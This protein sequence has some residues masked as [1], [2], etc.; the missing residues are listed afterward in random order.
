MAGGE[1]ASQ[2]PLTSG[3]RSTLQ[4]LT[5]LRS[6]GREQATGGDGPEGR[7]RARTSTPPP[8]PLP[9]PSPLRGQDGTA[10]GARGLRVERVPT[11]EGG[12]GS[13]R[14]P[15]PHTHFLHRSQLYMLSPRAGEG[16]HGRRG[17]RG[18]MHQAMPSLHRTEGKTTGPQGHRTPPDRGQC[19]S[20]HVTDS[21]QLGAEGTQPQR[22]K[23]AYAQPT[24]NTRLHRKAESFLHGQG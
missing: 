5:P 7:L 21:S 3:S 19:P 9:P 18:S 11:T 1:G 10:W 14:S 15:G 17:M 8:C 23:A 24:A 12:E 2:V 4:Y 20:F 6:L 22:R 16:R 13:G